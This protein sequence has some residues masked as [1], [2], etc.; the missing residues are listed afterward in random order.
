MTDAWVL[1]PIVV[2]NI[3]FYLK[4]PLHHLENMH[5]CLLH[6]SRLNRPRLTD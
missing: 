5:F 6:A 3:F 1:A 2:I 4:W